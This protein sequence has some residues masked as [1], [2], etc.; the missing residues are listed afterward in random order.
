LTPQ[1]KAVKKGNLEA[2]MK[3]TPEILY[4]NKKQPK[5]ATEA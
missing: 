2:T 1:K 3:T 4:L 5:E